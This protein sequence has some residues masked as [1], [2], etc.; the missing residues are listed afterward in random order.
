MQ[1]TGKIVLGVLVAVLLN[2]L[3]RHVVRF[4]GKASKL[5]HAECLFQYDE[6]VSPHL[7]ARLKD[8]ENA[9]VRILE[10]NPWIVFH[11]FQIPSDEIFIKSVAT[12][13]RE[14]AERTGKAAH[15]YV[16]TAGGESCILIH[17]R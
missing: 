15:V 7:A 4:G 13:I 3:Y 2:I 8:P 11:I 16:E 9:N 14:Y 12:R 17:P 1:T 6:P 10:M 5:I